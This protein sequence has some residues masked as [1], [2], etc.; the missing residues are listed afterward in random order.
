MFE[1]LSLVLFTCTVL[2]YDD[3]KFGTGRSD[4]YHQWSLEGLG[5][6]PIEWH[7]CHAIVQLDR[8]LS[9]IQA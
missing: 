7:V 9:S 2:D 6:S 4:T 3:V 8:S 1:K 5:F